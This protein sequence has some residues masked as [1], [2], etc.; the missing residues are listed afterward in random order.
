M[1]ENDFIRYASNHN[2]HLGKKVANWLDRKEVYPHN[3]LVFEKE[4]YNYPTNVLHFATE[5]SN[6]RKHSAVFP[7]ELPTWFIKLFTKK[8]DVVLDPFIGSGTTALSS[9]LLERNFIGIEIME[10][11][12]KE[13]KENISELLIRM[14]KDDLGK[15]CAERNHSQINFTKVKPVKLPGYNL[16]FNYYSISRNASAANIMKDESSSLYG[17]LINIEDK[18]KDIIGE[19]EGSP[20]YYREHYVNVEN[21]EGHIFN[22]VLTFKVVQKKEKDKDI[23]PTKYY[24]DLIIKNAIKYKFPKEYIKYLES[25]K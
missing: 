10:E 8:G 19:K 1:N 6:K 25:F 23:K 3:V 13:A 18:E 14:D 22:N 2:K 11:Y 17:L 9:I 16:C 5:C 15:W 4:H 20:N 24:L 12:V 7:I 21:S